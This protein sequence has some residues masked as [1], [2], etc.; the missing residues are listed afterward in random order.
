MRVKEL[1]ELL[2]SFDENLFVVFETEGKL[3]FDI[4]VTR[5]FNEADN[6]LFLF[7]KGEDDDG[8]E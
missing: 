6:C 7:D 4:G 1:I 3:S 5:G 8:D 2:K